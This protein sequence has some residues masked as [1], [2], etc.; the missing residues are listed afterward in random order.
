VGIGHLKKEP[1]DIIKI[2]SESKEYN[3]LK[4]TMLYN[5]ITSISTCASVSA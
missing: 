1:D 2:A 5:T 4:L 3:K